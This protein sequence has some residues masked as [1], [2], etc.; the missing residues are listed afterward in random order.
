MSK[1]TRNS[2]ALKLNECAAVFAALGDRTRLKLVKELSQGEPLSISELTQGTGLTR[3][4]VSKHL[5]VLEGVGL[6]HPFSSGRETRFELDTAPFK[7]MNEYLDFVAE[8]WDQSLNR[9]KKFIEDQ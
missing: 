3:Q 2:S 4:A 7:T 9:L 6:V 5:R 1:A 8:K